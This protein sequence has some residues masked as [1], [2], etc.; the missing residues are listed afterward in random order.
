MRRRDLDK[1]VLTAFVASDGTYRSP[2]VAVELHG[3][4]WAVSTN[5][6]AASIDHHG[7]QHVILRGD[8]QNNWAQCVSAQLTGAVSVRRCRTP[9]P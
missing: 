2:R 7:M 3:D 9:L 8:A 4:G 1:A 5:T 6:A